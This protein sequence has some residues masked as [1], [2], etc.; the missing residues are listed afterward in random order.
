MKIYSVINMDIVNSRNSENRAELQEQLKHYFKHLNLEYNNI[1]VAP[2]TFTLGD[3]WQIV[4]RCCSETYNIFSKI[5]KFLRKHNAAA[6]CG[7]GI[8]TI[9]TKESEDTRQM[10]GK[11]FIYAREA[12][13]TLKANS[14][15]SKEHIKTK[16]CK[17]LLI[18]E[19][20]D[21]TDFYKESEELNE[22]LDHSE[23][24]ATSSI[25]IDIV[26]L[27][28]T[29]IQNNELLESRLT[30]KQVEVI[31]LYEKYGSYK[32]IERRMPEYSK[33]NIS[34]KLSSANYFL[35]VNNKKT[36]CNLLEVYSTLLKGRLYEN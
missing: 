14:K 3:E 28:N 2:I 30:D 29:V 5:K 13:N 23:V 18:G 20:I 19:T 10:D 22:E 33:S 24:A 21:M 8:G 17:T 16:D 27:I 4:L 31:D 1:L 32:S 35:N 26:D 6:Y 34:H 11:A 15:I 36:I 12:L 25:E 9:S 7:I